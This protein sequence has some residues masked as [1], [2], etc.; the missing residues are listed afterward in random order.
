MKII[1]FSGAPNTGKTTTLNLLYNKVTENGTR[2]ILVAKSVLGNPKSNDFRCVVKYNN[3]KVGMF[4]MGD[5]F[6]SFIKAIIA[7]ANCDV[8]ILAYNNIFKAKLDEEIKNNYTFHCVVPKTI[9]NET[10]CD[11]I[12]SKI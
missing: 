9:S 10:D 3:K 11:T 5:Y 2:S 8:L 7:Y 12:L 4:T 1:L 6:G